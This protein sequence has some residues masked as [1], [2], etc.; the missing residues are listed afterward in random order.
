MRSP[1]RKPKHTRTWAQS[2]IPKSS[3][4]LGAENGPTSPSIYTRDTYLPI[5]I[6]KSAVTKMLPHATTKPTGRTLTSVTVATVTP[7]HS[8]AM[9]SLTS[10]GWLIPY[11]AH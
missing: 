6:W 2:H 10:R 11:T 1:L 3:C 9:L 7:T 5:H 4:H 8:T